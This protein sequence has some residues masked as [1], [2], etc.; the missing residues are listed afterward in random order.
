MLELHPLYILLVPSAFF[1]FLFSLLIT[2]YP[3]PIH[4]FKAQHK[5]HLLHKPSLITTA[6]TAHHPP[7]IWAVSL[8]QLGVTWETL[9]QILSLSQLFILEFPGR[10][11]PLLDCQE[12]N[13]ERSKMKFQNQKKERKKKLWSSRNR[14]E[15]PI[16]GR[17]FSRRQRKSSQP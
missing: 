9:I 8:S 17:P 4:P 10:I 16:L 3:I 5:S 13:G 14:K 2:T 12:G 11:L 6:L 15:Q 7:E 1:F